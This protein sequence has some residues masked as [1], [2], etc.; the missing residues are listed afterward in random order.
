M[1]PPDQVAVGHTSPSARLRLRICALRARSTPTRGH[2]VG[3]AAMEP[4]HVVWFKRDLRVADHAPL[5]E[6]ARRGPVLPLYV[7]EPELWAQPDASA[8][9]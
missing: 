4:V 7:V 6:V 3:S 2:S 9:Q 8:R 1:P 5:I